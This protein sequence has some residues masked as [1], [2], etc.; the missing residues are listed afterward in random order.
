MPHFV[1]VSQ[2]QCT[3]TRVKS[4]YTYKSHVTPV[5]TGPLVHCA[6]ADS[7]VSTLAKG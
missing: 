6:Q 7:A 5:G 4:R 2:D 3:H 1:K